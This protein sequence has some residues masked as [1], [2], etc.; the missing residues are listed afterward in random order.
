M[1]LF[2]K[3]G[4]FVIGLLF[5]L[6]ACAFADGG[7]LGGAISAERSGDMIEITEC[8]PDGTVAKSAVSAESMA[9]QAVLG[10]SSQGTQDFVTRL[11]QVVLERTPDSHGLQDWVDRLMSGQTTAAQAV[12]GF[13]NSPEYLGKGKTAEEIVT[14]CYNAMLGR[15]PDPTGKANWMNALNIGMT[16]TGILN[17]FVGS[18]EFF[19]LTKS[20]GIQPGTITLNNARDKS[21]PRTYFVY[22][23]YANGLG[24]TPD[25]A[26]LENWCQAL[27]NSS[28]GVDVASGFLFSQE[29]KDKHMSNEAFVEL[30][31]NTILGR[32]ASDSE[33]DSWAEKLNYTNT[34]EYVFNGF[35][36]SPEFGQQCAEIQAPVGEAL[37]TVDDTIEWQY[38]IE[39]LNLMNGLRSTYDGLSPFTT[40]EDLWEAAMTRVGELT[41]QFDHTRPDGRD[42]R[43]VLSDQGIAVNPENE[44]PSYECISATYTN[45]S[46]F[47]SGWISQIDMTYNMLNGD[48][49]IAATGYFYDPYSDYLDYFITLIIDVY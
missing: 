18:E 20:Y 5:L 43:T 34:R 25:M 3:C 6:Q 46:D 15:G 12:D 23:L 2:K 42:W 30:L 7:V 28:T 14:D 17:G 27:D 41:Y 32:G 21:Y 10:T 44:Y 13:F 11:Y 48:K 39:M 38:N 9:K 35:L 36:F 33:V 16:A 29:V 19:N 40:R 8:A 26:G 49:D 22:R 4:A 45:P 1:S 47:Y 37:A 31:Y 24:R